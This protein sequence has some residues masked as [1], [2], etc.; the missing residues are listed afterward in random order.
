MTWFLIGFREFAKYSDKTG[1]QF[2]DLYKIGFSTFIINSL[3][4][5][6]LIADKYLVNHNFP[7]E[8]A[9]A[10]TFSWG[11]IVP[12]LYIGN[13]VEKLIYSS[14]SGA[15]KVLFNKAAMLLAT[16]VLTY[17]AIL[18][19]TVNL[20]PGLLPKSVNSVMLK[21]ILN[22]MI[23]G[24]AI[25]SVVNFPING[26]LF[27]FAELSKQKKIAVLYVAT[28]FVFLIG[29]MLINGGMLINNYKVILY[30]IWVFIFILL[31]IKVAV[32]YSPSKTPGSNV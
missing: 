18:L 28:S 21:H 32:V 31:T 6:A 17:S 11:L 2:T 8:T 10:Y 15:K 12:I 5:L 22:F 13:L 25:F 29:F 30:A 23:W 9:N 1:S 3:V 20:F 19:I 4:S 26:Y 14:S 16:L 24:Y 27:K 7:L